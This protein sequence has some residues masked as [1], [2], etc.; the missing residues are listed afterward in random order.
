MGR[1]TGEEGARRGELTE[2]RRATN[3]QLRPSS[4][5]KR[6]EVKKGGR[7]PAAIGPLGVKRRR[8]AGSGGGAWSS[9]YEAG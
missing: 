6:R 8:L 3:A 7:W 1:V 4:A 2:R 9:T 5:L